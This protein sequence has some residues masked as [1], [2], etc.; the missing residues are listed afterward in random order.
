MPTVLADVRGPFGRGVAAASAI[1]AA[2]RDAGLETPVVV[3]GGLHDLDQ[4]EAILDEGLAD[5][6]AAAPHTLAGA[7]WL[8]HAGTRH[9]RGLLPCVLNQYSARLHTERQHSNF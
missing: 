9:R 1:R 8:L 5:I 6:V 7:D 2:V 3:S 4:M